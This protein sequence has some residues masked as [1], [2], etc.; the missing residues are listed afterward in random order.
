MATHSSIFAEEFHEQ[1][2]LVGYS[3]RGCKESDTTKWLPPP[4]QHEGGKNW[5]CKKKF[6][7][8]IELIVRKILSKFLPIFL[9]QS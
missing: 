2:S 6:V 8:P 4:Q 7:A 3:P 9:L 1:G 5:E